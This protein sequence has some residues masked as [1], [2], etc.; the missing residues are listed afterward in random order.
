[1][2]IKISQDQQGRLK[3]LYKTG[4]IQFLQ[5]IAESHVLQLRAGR[6]KKA[7]PD[8]TVWNLAESIGGENALHSYFITLYDLAN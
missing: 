6:T 8:D 1:M 2:E 5:G 7:T 3:N 4:D